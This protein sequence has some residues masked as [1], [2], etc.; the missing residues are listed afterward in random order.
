MKK[1]HKSI[2]LMLSALSINV[3]GQVGIGTS[4]VDPGIVLQIQSTPQQNSSYFGG[5]LFPRVA[6]TATDIFAPVSGTAVTG[7]MVYNTTANGTGNK[8]VVPG[9]YY[10]DNAGLI[11]K[12]IGQSPASPNDTALFANQDTSTDL[13][14]TDAGIAADLFANVRF[15][16]NPALYEKIDAKTLKINEVGYYKVILNLDL[17]ST[18][19]ADNFGVEIMVNGL[20]N[21]VSDNMY[22]P[23]RWDSGGG[24]ES[25]FPNGK[26]FVIYVPIN[27]AGYTMRVRTYEIDPATD[28]H[29]KNPNSS[30]ISIEKIR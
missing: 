18:G 2:L 27:V 17:A 14:G 28:V 23:G 15:N 26:S 22:I 13:N 21:I 1:I 16:S 25:H 19:G 24:L 11:W 8:A 10:W 29:F 5:I 4:S 6:L 3:F 30:T 7:L 9:L 12:R 20:G